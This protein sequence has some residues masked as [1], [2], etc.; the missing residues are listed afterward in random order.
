MK[1]A[2]VYT[3][4][5][6]LPLSHYCQNT[7]VRMNVFISCGRCHRSVRALYYSQKIAPS[8]SPHFLSLTHT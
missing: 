3:L 2:E 6:A 1:A 8:I 7:I 4:V 5:S